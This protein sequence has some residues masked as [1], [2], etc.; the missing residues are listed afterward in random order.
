MVGLHPPPPTIVLHPTTPFTGATSLLQG[1]RVHTQGQGGRGA[2]LPALPP[3]RPPS[4]SRRSCGQHAMGLGSEVEGLGTVVMGQLH[5]SYPV[6]NFPK[7]GSIVR[8]HHCSEPVFRVPGDFLKR[9]NKYIV[10]D[11]SVCGLGKC[12]YEKLPHG[13]VRPYHQKSSCLMQST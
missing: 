3:R 5:A 8:E 10:P 7:G 11:K 12:R 9:T 1:R 4:P 2:R 13:G 6:T